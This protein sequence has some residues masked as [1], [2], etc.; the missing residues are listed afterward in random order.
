MFSPGL[1]TQQTDL[2]QF[3]NERELELEWFVRLRFPA[4]LKT[5]L[6]YHQLIHI[7][8]TGKRN[9]N[10]RS[11]LRQREPLV[12]QPL[13]NVRVGFEGERRHLRQLQQLRVET[14]HVAIQIR[15]SSSS[16][17]HRHFNPTKK[18]KQKNLVINQARRS[19]PE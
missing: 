10:L 1:F 14:R 3:F 11:S 12:K 7:E 15:S 17:I 18:Q 19:D 16:C 5:K 2:T 13:D 9:D 8:M 4:L 6:P